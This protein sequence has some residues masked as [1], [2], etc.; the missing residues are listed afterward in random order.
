MKKYLIACLFFISQ[1]NYSQEKVGSV[2]YEIENSKGIYSIVDEQD[3][4]IMLIFNDKTKLD[5][6]SLDETFQ[7]TG[8]I[9]MIDESKGKNDY[10]GYSKNNQIYY[11][12]WRDSKEENI[13][14]K[15]VNLDK[16][17][18]T[19]S[20]I[21][22]VLEKEI[23]FN[24]A[25][26]NNI[27]YVLSIIK[28]TDILNIYTFKDGQM[29]KK[30]IDNSNLK[31]VN[32]E[33]KSINFWKLYSENNGTIYNDGFR[34]ITNKTNNS[35]VLSTQKKKSYIDGHSIIL[36]F[37]NNYTFNQ[38]LII[39][40]KDYTVT[41]KVLQHE[42][43]ILKDEF[44]HTDS[45]SFILNNKVFLV[46]TS[47]EQVFLTIK[48]LDNN[49]LKKIIY[50]S[51]KT[52]DF[53]N[54]DVVQE[55]G[56][57]NKKRVLEKPNQFTRKVH[58]LNPSITGVYENNKYIISLGGVSYPEQNNAMMIGGMLG[59]FTGALIGAL[60]SYKNYSQGINSYANKKIVY[61]KCVLDENF[62]HVNEKTGDSNF[63]K[64]R[65][66]IESDKINSYQ[67]IFE[68]NKSLIYTGYDKKTKTYN[69]YKF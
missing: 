20:K 21:P 48:D 56:S 33:N 60:V 37:D 18:T 26:I 57:I 51:N 66:F 52:S 29:N 13:E 6:I 61:L 62:N 45:N 28:N 53:I 8:K 15:E 22:F 44:S 55:H 43:V 50:S 27:F 12:Y 25:T 5:F 23:I 38:N 40:L 65:A 10:L 49:D 3:K 41:Q 2:N 59:G 54:S 4:K 63:D 11:T 68:L 39:N 24:S 17:T 16:N 7:Q 31:F 36:S 9:S 14:V 30:S 47:D 19:T 58:E 64:L 1:I 67:T 42:N 69:L 35:L 46:K 32:S 34:N